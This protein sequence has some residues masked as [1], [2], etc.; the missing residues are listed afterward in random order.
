MSEYGSF[1]VG[2][3][4]SFAVSVGASA[5]SS[6]RGRPSALARLSAALRCPALS[7]ALDARC[8][9]PFRTRFPEAAALLATLPDA[10]HAALARDF[11]TVHLAVFVTATLAAAAIVADQARIRYLDAWVLCTGAMTGGSL[12]PVDMGLVPRGA[13]VV[14][15]F[16]MAAG[17]IT[18]TALWPLGYRLYVF[19]ARLKPAL[20]RAR[21]LGPELRRAAR[22]RLP[23]AIS[24]DRTLAAPEAESQ[25]QQVQPQ[26]GAV[27][28]P[29]SAAA[30]LA[31]LEAADADTLLA[32]LSAQDEGLAAVAAI[33][34]VYVVF[35]TLVVMG[36]LWRRAVAP[37]SPLPAALAA[38]GLRPG[39]YALFFA[40]SALNNVGLSLFST[41]A[42]GACGGFAGGQHGVAAGAALP[43]A[44]LRARCSAAER[45]RR[46][47]KRRGPRP[48]AW[49][50]RRRAAARLRR[51]F[52]RLPLRAAA[53]ADVLPPPVS[54]PR[55]SGAASCAAP[56]K[57]GAACSLR[58]LVRA[59]A[60]CGRRRA[61]R[62]RPRCRRLLHRSQQPL[63]GTVGC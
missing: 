21:R 28:S 4:G 7:A 42:A 18:V 62:A 32:E 25:Q 53:P 52:A 34:L 41:S 35:W 56:H 6:D 36:A 60:G 19:R 51:L 38:R 23:R 26:P 8:A 31:A 63:D 16:L 14:L 29:E 10:A 45:A 46:R 24:E 40:T 22:P 55:D 39:W 47:S 33:T 20:R 61:R 9:A 5:A 15:W 48:G 1:F 57:H 44:A 12:S 17:G 2:G 13:Q 30:V 54:G 11:F 50:R 3:V 27:G 37:D 59:P 49:E 43:A 58:R